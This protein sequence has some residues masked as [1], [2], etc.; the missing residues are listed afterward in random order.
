[1]MEKSSKSVKELDEK[2]ENIMEL[3]SKVNKPTCLFIR[4]LRVYKHFL[5]NVKAPNL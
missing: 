3:K 1:M 5:K 4:Y 2:S